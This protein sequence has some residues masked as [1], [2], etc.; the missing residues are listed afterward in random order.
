MQG[1]HMFIFLPAAAVVILCIGGCPQPDPGTAVLGVQEWSPDA[2]PA[3]AGGTLTTDQ[4]PSISNATVIGDLT[5]EQPGMIVVSCM[6]SDTSGMMQSVTADLSAVGGPSAQA[7]SVYGTLWSWSGTVTPT[8]SGLQTITFTATSQGS[9]TRTAT[10]TAT[11]Q[12]AAASQPAAP[13]A[14]QPITISNIAV[15]GCTVQGQACDVTLSCSVASRDGVVKSVSANLSQV[16]GPALQSLTK[17]GNQWIWSGQITPAISGIKPIILTATNSSGT[18]ADA[19]ASVGVVDSQLLYSN[20]LF[21]MP[22]RSQDIQTVIEGIKKTKISVVLLN[23]AIWDWPTGRLYDNQPLEYGILTEA[24]VRQLVNGLRTNGIAVGFHSQTGSMRSHG[25]DQAWLIGDASSTGAVGKLKS[26]QAKIVYADGYYAPDM[27]YY[28]ETLRSTI[29]PDGIMLGIHYTDLSDGWGTMDQ[30]WSSHT[31][32][33]SH[34]R[35]YVEWRIKE[36]NVCR[37]TPSYRPYFPAYE[38]FD[39]G[40]IGEYIGDWSW[41][42]TA[43]SWPLKDYEYVWRRAREEN[44]PLTYRTT[45]E[46]LARTDDEQLLLIGTLEGNNLPPESTDRRWS[47]VAVSTDGTRM[48]AAAY[49]G[50]IFTSADS[51]VTWTERQPAGSSKNWVCTAMSSDGTRMVAAAYGDRVF[52]SADSGVTWTE[53]Q[54]AGNNSEG[55]TCVAMSSDGKTLIA[56]C[57]GSLYNSSTTGATHYDGRVYTSTDFGATWTQRLP[58][59]NQPMFWYWGAMSSTGTVLAMTGESGLRVSTNSGASWT[60]HVPPLGS[61]AGLGCVALS[62]N[63]TSIAAEAWPGRLYTSANSGTTWTERQPA[64]NRDGFWQCITISADGNKIMAGAWPGRLYLSTNFGATW[65][66]QQPAGDVDRYWESVA[67][68]QDG[69]KFIATDGDMIYT[70][71]D[72]GATWTKCQPGSTYLDL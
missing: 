43:P 37:K 46:S 70:S 55:W 47:S 4:P 54:P 18:T 15:L 10:A 72:S 22:S 44:L 2:N 24:Q 3:G 65:A 33:F 16:S 39:L 41:K 7:M 36:L 27:R 14:Q 35:E 52:A 34:P 57:D 67:I 45:M 40:W 26:L 71:A 50:S 25:R 68:S 28:C 29:G 1:L 30:G 51:G 13:P 58:M 12:V 60:S 56:T 6:A 63:G 8:T 31:W 66:E 62:A 21:V 38:R 9:T 53:R 64:G 42:T 11:M 17:N 49:G 23:V 48:I 59:V 69:T 5:Q 19:P 61:N 20:W 32:Y